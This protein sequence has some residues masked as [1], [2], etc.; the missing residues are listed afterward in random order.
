MA[1]GCGSSEIVFLIPHQIFLTFLD[2]LNITETDKKFYWHV[3]IV[4]SKKKEFLLKRKEGFA[5]IDITKY[6][7]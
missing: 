6:L 2:G 1:L 5:D 3:K 4:E 7:I